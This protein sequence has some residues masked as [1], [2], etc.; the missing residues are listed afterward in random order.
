MDDLAIQ[1]GQLDMLVIKDRDIADACRG[2]VE[3]HRRSE[4]AGA[5]NED[6]RRKKP[7]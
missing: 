2:K 3:D 4:A 6:T 7:L 5:D 1:I